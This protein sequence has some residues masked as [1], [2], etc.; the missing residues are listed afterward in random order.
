[1]GRTW[2]DR[3]LVPVLGFSAMLSSLQFTLIVPA[4][5]EIPQAF[6]VSAN[7]ATWMVTITLLASTVGSPIVG[8]LADMYG[9]RRALLAVL[10]LLAFGSLIAAIGMTF[11]TVLIGRAL[12]G[13]A[14]TIVPVGISLLREVVGRER[15]N[16]GIGFISATLGIGS[17][18][19]LPLSG[20]LSS[21]GGIAA[22]FWFS[23]VMGMVFL[24]FAAIVV[25]EPPSRAPGGFDVV[26]AALLSIALG[27]GLIALSKVLV[28]GV[29]SAELIVTLAVCL[30]AAAAWVARSLRIA[31]PII[32]L[33][34]SFSRRVLTINI[35]SFLVTFGM[36]SNH[37]LT[38]HEARAP[39]ETGIGLELPALSAGLILVPSAIALVS[40]APVA[41]LLLNRIGGRATLSL[42]SSLIAAAYLFRLLVHGD[43]FTV[44]LGAF[45]VG[46]GT[47]FA[48]AAMPSL[49]N[50]A[51][52][53]DAL[54]SANAVNAVLRSMSGATASAALAFLIVAMSNA[55]NPD[56]LSDEGLTMAFG[57]VAV[58]AGSAAVAALTL[59]RPRA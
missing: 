11:V 54:A 35:A 10:G 47:A 22:L 24:T 45:L 9:R 43:L 53:L 18:L 17:A 38:I 56:F 40:L 19:G 39:L 55:V 41:G 30:V 5:P 25:P 36:F 42:G 26:G 59:P 48:F 31:H 15:S 1:M 58:F 33:R 4:L 34:L 2:R 12:Q 37:L 52:P 27:A 13:L 44:A 20:I 50:D 32:D 8:R 49:I 29:G 57:I 46:V 7:D 23:A 3:A 6:D 28:W 16:A 51:V 14:A 21:L